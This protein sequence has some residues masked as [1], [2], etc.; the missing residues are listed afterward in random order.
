MTEHWC[1][2]RRGLCMPFLP[3]SPSLGPGCSNQ[4]EAIS[5]EEAAPPPPPP[6]A[7]PPAVPPHGP[8]VLPFTLYT[9]PLLILLT[10]MIRRRG[11]LREPVDPVLIRRAGC[12]TL[13][14]RPRLFIP[15]QSV[16]GR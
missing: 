6:F 5:S 8:Q 1:A 13:P 14:W 12:A 9:Q 10:K 4:A 16:G 11:A 3:P 15:A 7:M 2:R